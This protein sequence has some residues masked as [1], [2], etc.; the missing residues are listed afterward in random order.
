[1]SFII[2]IF[3]AMAIFVFAI[4][5]GIS[6]SRGRKESA[7]LSP[8]NVIATGVA[9]S[10]LVMYLP[11]YHKIFDGT[12]FSTLKTI[13][14]SAHNVLQLFVIDVDYFFVI[15]NLSWADEWIRTTYSV[16]AAIL[17][18]VAPI[19]TFGF[20]LSLFKNL[21]AHV[22]YLLSYFKNVYIFS[23]IND[24][25]I[26]LAEDIKK[27]HPKATIVFTDI[28]EENKENSFEI[29]ERAKKISA[30]LFKKDI[31]AIN[32]NAHSKKTEM[33]FF[34]M[35]ENENEN[36]NQGIAIISRY[37]KR[38]NSNLYVFS[39]R[40]EGELLLT[41][42]DKGGMKVRRINE[43]RS[44]INR[45]LYE[46]GKIFFDGAK[47]QED[48]SRLISAV[49]VG[50]GKHGTE[51]IKALSW[52]C[53][54]TD[55]RIEITA[56]D[57]DPL[58]EERF[59]ALCP[60]LMSDEYN[61]VYVDGEAQY[62]I[63]IKSGYDIDT[64]SFANEIYSLTDTTYVLC[65]LGTDELNIRASVN[66]RMYFERIGIKPTIQSIIYNSDARASL[67]GIKNYK[68]QGYE[69]DFIGDLKT[70]CSERV[71]LDSELEAKAL[72]RHLKWGQEDDFWRF[73]YNYRSSTASAIHM[74]MREQLVIPSAGKRESELTEEEIAIIEPLEHRR[75]NAYM[76]S[77]GYVYSGSPDASSRNDLGK[78]HHDL[79]PFDTLTD[80]DKRK[81]RRVGTK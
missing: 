48:G 47:E 74:N 45:L 46:N 22:R 73:E 5:W 37:G 75:W 54:M 41:Q 60:E 2:C 50:M 31:V 7:V 33:Y 43:T 21:S 67:E 19:L 59:T 71:I 3:I 18:I 76:R 64:S 35:G 69:I 81:D 62:K 11:I 63:T 77:E 65:S 12:G 40:V 55:Y 36:L 15:E 51:M 53:Q 61:G 16:F 56:F 49:I 9:I 39:T 4:V 44:L 34:I 27:N 80:E 1:M 24:Q 25:T 38:K 20:I 14:M 30:I 78:M 58:A 66:L 52:F 72:A 10:A 68:G 57:K 79:V 13:L 32:F 42:A 26:T 29:V 70:S 28:F 17:C 6:L 23:E 8:F